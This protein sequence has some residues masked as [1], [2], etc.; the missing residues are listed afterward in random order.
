[1]CVGGYVRFMNKI[2]FSVGPKE[3]RVNT[4][5]WTVWLAVLNIERPGWIDCYDVVTASVKSVDTVYF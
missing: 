3:Y 2:S 1:V 4:E 5:Q